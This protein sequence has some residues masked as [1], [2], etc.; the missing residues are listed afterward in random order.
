MDV[1]REKSH[2]RNRERERE[3]TSRANDGGKAMD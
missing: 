3:E 2:G 1:W